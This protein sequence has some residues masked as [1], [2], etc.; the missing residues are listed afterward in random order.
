[1]DAIQE[2]ASTVP[3]TAVPIFCSLGAFT[4]FFSAI[5]SPNATNKLLYFPPP[6]VRPLMKIFGILARNC[7]SLEVCFEPL[8]SLL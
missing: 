8:I 7:P 5:P 6:K 3:P 2:T 1:M 4:V